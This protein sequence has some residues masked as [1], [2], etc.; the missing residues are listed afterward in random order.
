MRIIQR[1]SWVRS[2]RVIVEVEVRK[3]FTIVL[4]QTFYLL[5]Y[6]KR[7]NI[8]FLSMGRDFLIQ[9]SGLDR[10]SGYKKK[11]TVVENRETGIG[12]ESG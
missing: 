10:R 3:E 4:R 9:N 11:K 1:R 7:V 8:K 6:F 2:V 5:W 12:D